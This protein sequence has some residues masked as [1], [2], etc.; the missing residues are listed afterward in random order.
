MTS[1]LHY[2]SH[3]H[4]SPVHVVPNAPKPILACLVI[5]IY[6]S[7]VQSALH[8]ISR[9]TNWPDIA[10][11]QSSSSETSS[12]CTQQTQSHLVF[13][14][15]YPSIHHLP[16]SIYITSAGP[17][18]TS[19]LHSPNHPYHSPVHVVPSSPKTISSCL[20][21]PIYRVCQHHVVSAEPP[22]ASATPFHSSCHQ[23]SW[24]HTMSAG[25]SSTLS[26]QVPSTHSPPF[27][28]A[29]HHVCRTTTHKKPTTTNKPQFQK[30][31]WS[32]TTIPAQHIHLPTP[33]AHMPTTPTIPSY[34]LQT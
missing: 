5:S 19:T 11:S 16:N 4:H 32:C 13:A 24:Q 8:C 25:P 34:S 23:H 17:P 26:P 9:T 18:I 28:L 22:T 27:T 14:L 15:S 21:I 20:I 31:P 7:L 29:L 12:H 10:F 1:T 33:F 3:P 6:P 2:P 30:I